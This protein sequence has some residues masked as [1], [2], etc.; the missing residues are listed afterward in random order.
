M[1]DNLG[2]LDLCTMAANNIIDWVD[3]MSVLGVPTAIE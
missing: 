2:L 3:T 1:K